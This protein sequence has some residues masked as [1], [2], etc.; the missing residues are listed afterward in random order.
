MGVH[1]PPEMGVHFQTEW[2]YTLHREWVYIFTGI[3]N[4]ALTLIRL[5]DLN[6]ASEYL[7]KIVGSENRYQRDAAQILRKIEKLKTADRY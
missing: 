4:L 6:E 2:L 7:L 3:S 5:N 1:F